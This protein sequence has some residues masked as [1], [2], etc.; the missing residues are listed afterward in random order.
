MA[1]CSVSLRSE[2]SGVLLKGRAVQKLLR[3]GPFP[4]S[5]DGMVTLMEIE[6]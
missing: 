1:Y 3:E 2:S 6:L 5:D 4:S